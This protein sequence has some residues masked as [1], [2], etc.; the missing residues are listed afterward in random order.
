MQSDSPIACLLTDDELRARRDGILAE[1]SHAASGVSRIG[2]GVTL[3]LA[4]SDE[5]LALVMSVVELERQCCPFLRF[6]ITVEPERGPIRL[7][8]TGPAG[9]GDFISNLLR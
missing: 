6:R 5:A 8:I 2:E 3:E 7:E 9:T 1:L 4:P